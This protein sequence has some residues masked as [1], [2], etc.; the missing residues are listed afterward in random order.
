[1]RAY[2]FPDFLDRLRARELCFAREESGEWGRK[3]VRFLW[4]GGGVRLLKGV[5][6]DGVGKRG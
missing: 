4:G 2:V 1:M 6:F 3:G 5:G